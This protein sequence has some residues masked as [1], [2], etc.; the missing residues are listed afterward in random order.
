VSDKAEVYNVRDIEIISMKNALIL[1][2]TDFGKEQKQRFNNWFPWLKTEL[3]LL[4]YEVW[5]P[6][7]PQAW[8]P[9]L[10]RYWQFLKKFDF[11]EETIVVGHSSGGAMVFGLLHK[12]TQEKKIKLGISVAGFY[13][14]DGW[15]C[16][17]LF[18]EEYDWKKIKQQAEKILLLWSPDDKYIKKEQTNYLA[19][20]LNVVPLVY[21]NMGHFSLGSHKRFNQ[22]PELLELIKKEVL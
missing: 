11:N 19:E 14:D 21:E 2:G 13:Y 18:S 6:E 1:H 3:E 4:D 10:E 7:L 5:V 12:L 15:N 16:E 17:G 20:K 9:D 8:E 22:F